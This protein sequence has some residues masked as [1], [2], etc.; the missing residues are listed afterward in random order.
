MITFYSHNIWNNSP[1]GYRTKLLR[2]LMGDF[3]AD[4]CAFQECSPIRNRK[5]LPTIEETMGD[6][7][8]EA[9]PQFAEENYTPIFYKKDK[10]NVID[11]DFFPYA[12]LNDLGSKSVSW[13]ILEDKETGERFAFASTH[14]WWMAR[15]EEDSNQ[16]V[17]N[18]KQLKGVCDKI[19]EKHNIP[20]FIGGDFNNGRNSSQGDAPYFEMLKMG[21]VD[22]RT[23][24]EDCTD[25]EFTCQSAVPVLQDDESFKPVP[26]D[27]T[28]CIDY[29]FVYGDFKGKVKKFYIETNDKARTA[30]DHTPLIAQ[31]EF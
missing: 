28:M 29:I 7:Y 17:E 1:A 27:A 4:V 18:A 9:L 23:I 24:A 10:F 8:L 12:G 21:F 25:V 20:V 31:I 5:D 15:G 6:V 30:S 13:A 11:G 22:I 14:F 19:I 26:I 3:D 2:E 16:R